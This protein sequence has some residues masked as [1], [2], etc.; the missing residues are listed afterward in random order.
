[1]ADEAEN[2]TGQE[3]G[4]ERPEPVEPRPEPGHPG[5]GLTDR[6]KVPGDVPDKVP[7]KVLHIRIDRVD[8]EVGVAKL[9]GIELRQL[10][11]PPILPDR[12]LYEDVPGGEDRK[13][14]NDE[15][16]DLHDGQRFFTAPSTINPGAGRSGS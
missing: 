15:T 16:V 13:I 10:P 14:K 2:P 3:P 8:Y 9:S 4:R 11:D 1:M 12:D 6:P 7:P 5:D